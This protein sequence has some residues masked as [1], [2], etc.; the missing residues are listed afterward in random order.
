[1]AKWTAENIPNL[2]GKIALITGANSGLGFEASLAFAKK[3]ATVVMACRDM[4]K[5]QEARQRI[6]NEVSG[7]QLIVMELNLASLESIKTFAAR[8]IQTYSH[9]DILLNN[10]GVMAPPY[11][12]TEDGFE[13]Q[14]GTNHFGHFALTGLL[15]KRVLFT[16]NSRVVVVSSFAHHMGRINFDDL[17]WTHKYSKWPAY[18]QSKLAN[19]LFAYELDRRFKAADSNSIAMAA[20]PGY[21]ATHLQRHTGLFAFL[22]T[23]L[24][25]SSYMGALPILFA[26]TA[27]GVQGA[28]FYGPDGF[29]E[30]RGYPQKTRSSKASYD[31]A[32]AKRLWTVSEKVT[33]VR[34]AFA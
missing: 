4:T 16:P 6:E 18:G 17:N 9:L 23:F 11:R 29:L 12:R 34:Y 24:A 32:L 22:N 15:L 25:Q 14:I 10:A 7:A 19:L 28:E 31:A 3:Y 30:M 5:G 2:E 13:L 1:M 8:F 26:A 21:S 27:D 33:G 20:H